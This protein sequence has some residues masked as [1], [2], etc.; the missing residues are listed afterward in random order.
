MFDDKINL[1]NKINDEIIAAVEYEK[2]KVKLIVKI[3]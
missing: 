3:I 2:K 1:A